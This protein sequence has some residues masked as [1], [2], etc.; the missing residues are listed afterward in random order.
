MGTYQYDVDDPTYSTQLKKY[1]NIKESV[2]EDNLKLESEDEILKLEIEEPYEGFGNFHF[3][4]DDIKG[5]LLVFIVTQQ[6][7]YHSFLLF[8]PLGTLE[9]YSMNFMIDNHEI[10]LLIKI[11]MKKNL[12]FRNKIIK[13]FCQSREDLNISL[14]YLGLKINFFFRL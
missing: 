8:T 1:F 4:H 9:S 5:R 10:E 11:I 12:E 7:D 2:K 3:Y 14:K 6:T 13:E